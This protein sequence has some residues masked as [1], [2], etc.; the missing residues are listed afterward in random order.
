MCLY[1]CVHMCV[2]VC[3]NTHIH[4]CLKRKRGKYVYSVLSP[5]LIALFYIYENTAS[6]WSKG[7]KCFQIC[8][9]HVPPISRGGRKDYC[10]GTT[11]LRLGKAEELGCSPLNGGIRTV[12]GRHGGRKE[13]GKWSRDWNLKDLNLNH[14]CQTAEP[15]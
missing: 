1:V 9:L 15:L 14:R 5:F 8:D 4:T 6:L 2:H 12:L 3:M 13:E 7:S 10:F 11:N